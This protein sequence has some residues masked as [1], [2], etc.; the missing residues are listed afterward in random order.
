MSGIYYNSEE[1]ILIG[2]LIKIF[3]DST[4]KWIKIV[5]CLNSSHNQLKT[6]DYT[7]SGIR[8]RFQR[9]SNPQKTY[10]RKK[11]KYTLKKYRCRI[12]KKP[13]KGHVCFGPSENAKNVKFDTEVFCKKLACNL[14]FYIDPQVCP[15]EKLEKWKH[16]FENV[17]QEDEYQEYQKDEYQEYQK[18]E[19]REYEKDEYQDDEEN[20]EFYTNEKEE[21]EQIQQE[22]IEEQAQEEQ[23][24]E[25]QVQEK[26]IQEE[27][28]QEEQVQEEQV[29]EEQIHQVKDTLYDSY[30]KENTAYYEVND[31]WQRLQTN[32]SH[33]FSFC[34]KEFAECEKEF[35]EWMLVI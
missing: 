15:T 8:N 19:Y 17:Y 5:E 12:C 3:A 21:Q 23:A 32:R 10:D 31:I 24:Q 33:T 30:D 29:Q 9:M 18:D 1:N 14:T 27:Q 11:K 7:V 22:Q 20:K 13:S 6:R 16:D 34:E 25:E 28:V 35:A 2:Y 26:Q 4:S